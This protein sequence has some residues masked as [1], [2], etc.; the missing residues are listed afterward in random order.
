MALS[1]PP[2]A[3]FCAATWPVL[4]PP[5]TD[6]FVTFER[7]CREGDLELAEHLFQALETIA[8]REGEEA[9]LQRAYAV[10]IHSPYKCRK[11]VRH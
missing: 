4:S 5:L 7:A 6:V 1:A 2:L 3:Y 9:W 10:L 8:Q 11:Q